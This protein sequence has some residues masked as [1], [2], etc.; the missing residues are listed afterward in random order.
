VPA[1]I[2]VVG[3]SAAGL[4]AAEGLRS[5]GYD[6]DL[7]VVDPDPDLPYERPTLSKAFLSGLAGPEPERAVSD[8]LNRLGA[9]VRREVAVGLDVRD[10]VLTLSGGPLAYSHLVVATG[11][12]PRRPPALDRPE[13]VHVLR[14]LA[15]ARALR[16]ALTEA[17]SV[18]V[19]GGGF[20]GTEVTAAAAAAG[21]AV[22]VVDPLP[23]PLGVLGDHVS[24]RIADLH[25][26]RG[27]DLLLGCGVAEVLGGQRATGVRLTDGRIVAAD[28]V[29]LALG[30]EP[31]DRWLAGSQL[32]RDDG[33]VV[34][35]FLRAA[36]GVLAAGD[37][38]R[39]YHPLYGTH[40]RIEHWTTAV[41]H[42]HLAAKVIVQG[43][44]DGL[45]PDV[46]YVWS[47]QYDVRLSVVGRTAGYEAHVV[48]RHP[49]ADRFVVAYTDGAGIVRGALTWNWTR[50]LAT[51][52]GHVA[53][54]VPLAD[55]T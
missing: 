9:D 15:D 49:D 23:L 46:P 19:V 4:G 3:A 17:G 50:A 6:G 16:A 30:V 40:L 39:A 34:D 11:A 43:P 28:V 48:D 18:V 55:A 33:I 37:V 25:R 29:L 10:H 13:G 21:R 42:G 53:G 7:V 32:T 14:D 5:E 27:V 47:E 20:L 51:W 22:T 52:R 12:T 41:A 38:A 36:D 44:H 31:A 8:R 2:V 24:G 45:V 1:P 35:R 26:A 54:C